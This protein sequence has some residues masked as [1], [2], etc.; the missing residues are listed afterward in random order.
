LPAGLVQNDPATET[1]K[2]SAR[3]TEMRTCLVKM[4]KQIA[5]LPTELLVRGKRSLT[6]QSDRGI[7]TKSPGM[8]FYFDVEKILH[9]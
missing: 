8:N 3:S 1:I 5:F 6:T 9:I 4:R 7:S 2:M